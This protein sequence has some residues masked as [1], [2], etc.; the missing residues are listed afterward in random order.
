[1]KEVTVYNPYDRYIL[2]DCMG[3]EDPLN[4]PLERFFMEM[5]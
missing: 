5:M 3:I 1:M 2:N 4:A